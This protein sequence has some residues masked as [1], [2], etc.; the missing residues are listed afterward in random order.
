MP[1]FRRSSHLRR[2][3][4]AAAACTLVLPAAPAAAGTLSTP[5]PA[6]GATAVL[7]GTGAKG[8]KPKVTAAPRGVV[9]LGGADRRG[10]LALAVV[11]PPGA[12]GG[13]VRL[14]ARGSLKA[15]P[16]ATLAAAACGTSGPA[17]RLRTVLRR[18]TLNASDAKA[19]GAA[20]ERRACGRAS[21]ADSALLARLGLGQP[22]NPTTGAAPQP[23]GATSPAPGASTPPKEILPPPAAAP[24]PAPPEEPGSY[25]A[26]RDGVDNDGD[27]QTDALGEHGNPDPGCF[28]ENDRTETGETT[29]SAACR[30]VSGVSMNTPD[31]KAAFAAVN[32]DCGISSEVVVTVQPGILACDVFTGVTGYVCAIH[33]RWVGRT[34]QYLYAGSATDIFDMPLTLTD[35]VDC[36][37]PATIALR[38]PDLSVEEIVEPIEPCPF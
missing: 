10:R 6:A 13:A 35:P 17:S 23:G 16:A 20:M 34:Y 26:C 14:R 27:G 3:A 28:N 7:L 37:K 21:A 38:R 2:A 24:K 25:G 36:S 8:V 9:V 22:A 1:T 31:P 19:L 4:L 29:A 12:Q 5:A 11:R 33:P 18:G 15:K 30:A 32:A